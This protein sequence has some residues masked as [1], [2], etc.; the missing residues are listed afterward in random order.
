MSI[1]TILAI[2]AGIFL[3]IHFNAGRNAVWGGATIGSIVGL[4]IALVT[5][6]WSKLTL[7]FAIGTLSGV[8]ANLI[9]K[10]ADAEKKRRGY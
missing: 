5:G 10:F 1:E 3:L 6:D 8:L 4:I 7:S 2:V 9:G